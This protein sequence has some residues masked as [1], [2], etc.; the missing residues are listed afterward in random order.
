M[1]N[2]VYRDAGPTIA[3]TVTYVIPII[4]TTAGVLILNESVAFHEIIGAAVI[5]G[6]LLLTQQRAKRAA[7]A[8]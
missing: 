1:M 4:S 7:K 8:A 6:G 5:I 3:S 2:I